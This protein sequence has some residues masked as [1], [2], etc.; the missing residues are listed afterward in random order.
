MTWG[1]ARAVRCGLN[2]SLARVG[3]RGV[4]WPPL[5]SYSSL[6][7]RGKKAHRKLRSMP[8]RRRRGPRAVGGDQGNE[9]GEEAETRDEGG[10][11]HLRARRRLRRVPWPCV[12][13]EMGDLIIAH[14]ASTTS[15]SLFQH[16][17]TGKRD[18]AGC[19]RNPGK[20]PQW[21]TIDRL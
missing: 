1:W 18:S 5:V 21:R 17:L 14:V 19:L 3:H 2:S 7:A 10:T 16:A 9:R 12:L 15:D 6:L 11:A 20:H 4:L 8:A 13:R